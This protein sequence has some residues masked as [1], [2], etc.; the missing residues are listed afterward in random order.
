MTPTTW[1][2]T[3]WWRSALPRLALVAVLLGALLAPAAAPGQPTAGPDGRHPRSW[4]LL[5]QRPAEGEQC[6]VCRVAVHEGDIV[7]VRYKGRTFFVAA[8]MLA[9]FEA[10]PDAYFHDLQAHGGLFDEGAM[11]SPPTETGWLWLGLYIL[12]GLVAGAACSYAA[13]NRGL[14]AWGWFFAGLL[15]NAI[16]LAAVLTRP[17]G[18]AAPAAGLAPGLAKIPTTRAPIDCERCGA[19]NHPAAPECS[20]CG[21]ALSPAIE[22]ETARA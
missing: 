21:H 3:A 8:R 22:P 20:G 19:A 11:E 6:I 2:A 16:A 17:R 18:A 13:L 7:E 5:E 12:V 4:E 9:E 15:T 10:H 14:P 1:P